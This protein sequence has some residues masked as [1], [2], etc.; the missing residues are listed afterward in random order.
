M[1]RNILKGCCNPLWKMVGYNI[2]RKL[3]K[4]LMNWKIG[5]LV[6]STLVITENGILANSPNYIL[7]ATV[8]LIFFGKKKKNHLQPP[9]WPPHINFSPLRSTDRG[10]LPPTPSQ[11]PGASHPLPSRTSVFTFPPYGVAEGEHSNPNCLDLKQENNYFFKLK[12]YSVNRNIIHV[13][14]RRIPACGHLK[15]FTS[16]RPR[17]LGL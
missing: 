9:S 12:R 5:K 2:W 14:Q 4:L 17:L 11:L 1:V 7:C 15:Q 3:T 10:S 6:T 16:P 8:M 13:K